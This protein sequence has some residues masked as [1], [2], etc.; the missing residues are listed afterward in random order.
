MLS[1]VFYFYNYYA[2][3]AQNPTEGVHG[4]N[5]LWSLAVEEHF[6]LLFPLVFV[7]WLRKIARPVHIL[8]LLAAFCLWRLILWHVFAIEANDIYMRSDTRFDSILWGCF[9]ALLQKDGTAARLFPDRAQPR[10]WILLAAGVILLA[11][12]AVREPAFRETWRYSLQGIALMPVFHYA[13]TR[14]D[15]P[16]FRPLN[17]QPIALVGTLSYSL[18]L[19]HYVLLIWLKDHGILPANHLLAAVLVGGLALG[20][21]AL[22]SRLIERP[23]APTAQPHHGALRGRHAPSTR[24]I[25]CIR[26]RR[27]KRRIGRMGQ[28][29]IAVELGRGQGTIIDGHIRNRA[30]KE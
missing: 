7:L 4:F 13:V 2:A 6:Y 5:V 24:Q 27:H 20:Y 8:G 18:Y 23:R 16:L 3:F 21:A 30:V 15:L 14:P 12:F 19:V 22:L 9:F 25:V 26:G 29:L 17:W 11:C 28:R 1:Q 10:V